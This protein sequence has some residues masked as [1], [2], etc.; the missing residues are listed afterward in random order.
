MKI[1]ENIFDLIGNT[2]LLRVEKNIFA[3]LEFQNPGSSIKDRAALA[4]IQK[5]ESLGELKYGGL[6][7]EAS[8]GNLGI[9]LAIIG[10][11]KGYS[12]KIVLPENFSDE[13][14]KILKQLGAEL[15][16][17]PAEE[18]MAGAIRKAE[19]LTE[20]ENGWQP[21]Q[22]ENSANTEIHF[23][24]TGP[25]IFEALPEIQIF[26]AGVGSGGT[27]SG[28]GKFFKSQNSE[29]KIVAVEPF[30]S[31]VLSGGEKGA[32]RIE[33]IGAGF[34]PKNFDSKIIDEI[35]KISS[36]E[37][38]AASKNLARAKGILV[39]ISSGANFAAAQK[40]AEKFPDQKITT[41]FPDGGERYLSTELFD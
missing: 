15:I 39:G 11:R 17:T 27:I 18:G 34:I 1:S 14:K 12:V 5:A 10:K 20:K 37:A 9:S 40:L 22:F 3:K 7:V 38:I 24:T 36:A 4:M 30:E 28:V 25:E 2:P 41:I 31:A 26:V 21:R 19:K 32:H 29:I 6:I 13:R 33:G 8:S 35:I 16:L 23:S